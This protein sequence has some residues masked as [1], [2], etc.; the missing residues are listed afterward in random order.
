MDRPTSPLPRGIVRLVALAFVVL[1]GTASAEVPEPHT[2][3][4]GPLHGDVPATLSGAQIIDAKALADLIQAGGIV[5]VDAASV[6]HRPE[7]L[8]SDTIWKPV[9]HEHISGSIW[10]PGIGEGNIE[11]D[12]E[13]FFR[14]RLTTLTGND[15]DRP[16]VFYC[17]PMCWASWNAA[18]RAMSFGYRKV[19]WYPDGAEGWQAAGHP[20][21]AA[22]QESPGRSGE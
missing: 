8:P 17:H 4:M 12:M 22:H 14:E 19:I 7:N 20:L 16:I 18:K 9:P 2:Y 13:A 21:V 1:A 3:W 11:K 10:I 5:L 15:L 6:P